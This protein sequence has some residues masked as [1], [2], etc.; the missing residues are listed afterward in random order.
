LP[1]DPET[2][3]AYELG[4]KSELLDRRVALNL[5]AFYTD[6]SN[7]Q[8]STNIP[9]PPGSANPQETVVT[10]G[11][12]AKLKGFEADL[13]ARPAPGFTLRASLGY[14]DS[15]FR[16]LVVNQPIGGAL[17][18]VDLSDVDMIYAPKLTASL[19]AEYSIP[20]DQNEV[21]LTAGWRHLD[22]YDQQIAADPA[23][24]IPATG[25]IVVSRNDP[26]LR[27]DVQNLV[28]ASVSY[29]F[30]MGGGTKAHVSLYGRNLLD[31][32]GPVTSFTVGA[33]PTLWVFAAAREPRT[34]GATIGFEF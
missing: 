27:S 4:V 30:E 31:D 24:P 6:Y 23:T 3:K 11:A 29:L 19:G 14:T 5:A 2:V 12:K 22:K 25:V 16:G 33:F 13:T 7:I 18:T 10:N 17:R 9:T 28:D 32:R 8:Q 15:G 1:Y 34:Y 26:R 20:L 21:K